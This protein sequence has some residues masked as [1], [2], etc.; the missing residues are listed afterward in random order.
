MQHS[1]VL[2]RRDQVDNF[3]QVQTTFY[4]DD[5]ESPIY[6]ASSRYS[7][8]VEGHVSTLYSRNVSLYRDSVTEWLGW[9]RSES[10][11]LLSLFP[12]WSRERLSRLHSTCQQSQVQSIKLLQSTQ[13]FQRVSSLLRSSPTFALFLEAD[14]FRVHRKLVWKTMEGQRVRWKSDETGSLTVSLLSDRIPFVNF[15]WLTLDW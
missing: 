15:R 2:T 11:L 12:D 13:L 1:L 7:S 4:R 10:P 3:G 8:I 9:F 14:S 6:F 5:S